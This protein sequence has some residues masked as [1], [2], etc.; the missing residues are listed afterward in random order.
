M[1]F[2]NCGHIPERW[3]IHHRGIWTEPVWRTAE[4]NVSEMDDYLRAKNMTIKNIILFIF[5]LL[6]FVIQYFAI[7]S[8]YELHRDEY[9][10][11]DLG[12]HL[13]WGYTTVP[14][15][16]GIISY[17]IKL[18]GNSVFW[19]KFFPALFGALIIVVVSKCVEELKGGLFALILASA[20]VIFSVFLRINTLYQPNSLDFLLWTL[21]FFAILKYINTENNKWLYITSLTF[22]VAFLNKYNISFLLFG[23][24]P[25]LL[26]TNYKKIFRNKH[27]YF[28]I[29]ISLILILPNLIWQYLNDF[30]VFNHLTRLRDTQ[31]VNVNRLDFL[32]EQI[33]FFVGS[34]F[35]IIS[36][37][38]SFF[39]Y[40]PFKKYK[41]FFLTY[42]FTMT[43]FVL[44]RAKNYYTI[45]LY[46]IFLAFGSVYLEKLL[47][48]GWQKYLRPLVILI[49]ILIIIPIF[50]LMLPVL[51]PEEIIR[52]ADMFKK[53]NLTRWEDG[54]LHN[55]PQ[56]YSDMLGWREL[57]S[58]VDSAF[59]LIDDKKNTIIHCDNYGEAGAI[60]FY[61]KQKYTQAVS[62]SA[63]YI[64]WYPLNDV[65]I[66]NVIM[67][68]EKY[69]T[70][71]NRENEKPL[72]KKI[73]IVGEVKNENAREKGTRVYLLTGAKQSI[74]KILRE[75]ILEKKSNR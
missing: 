32:K 45:G 1:R 56:D 12:K 19:I 17:I 49:P 38:I 68:K 16:T 31:L 23:L 7:D 43:L 50:Q 22:S 5:I 9:L 4:I 36:A 2:A 8:G 69:D 46:P 52:K 62:M 75:E 14:P 74:N 71:K 35:V 3:T 63:D 29:V 51:S 41:I 6:K 64:N 11:L 25:A 72:F 58:I 42:I 48:S 53:F 27:F 18:L 61:S 13:A 20:S 70:D 67:V 55:L 57:A 39:S 34:F 30:P 66:N 37:F 73:T 24:L 21:M 44:L 54:Q 40:P 28:S 65:E 47:E 59:A 10:H 33:L 60:N 15:I 26:F